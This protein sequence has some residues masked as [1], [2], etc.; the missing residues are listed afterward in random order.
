M[1]LTRILLT[2]ATGTST[3]GLAVVGSAQTIN[4]ASNISAPAIN[5]GQSPGNP[6]ATG[7]EKANNPSNNDAYESM[8]MRQ[9]RFA[10][11]QGTPTAPGTS[12]SAVSVTP[13]VTSS[14]P[15]VAK[16]LDVNGTVSVIQSTDYRYRR[17]VSVYVFSHVAGGDVAL[18]TIVNQGSDRL[19]GETRA[20]A[21]RHAQ[22]S[23]SELIDTFGDA[24][25]ASPG[26]WAQARSEMAQGYERYAAAVI[27][28]ENIATG[29]VV[30]AV[31]TSP[32]G[33]LV[34]SAR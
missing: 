22:R 24:I 23:R 4:T 16:F 19:T 33:V 5:P 12:Q 18:D 8:G 30:S 13:N 10:A 28:V 1:K 25:A 17:D 15:S 7:I 2:L 26:D 29:R 32:N 6:G 34:A 3:V 20:Q 11:S 27:H 9:D 21:L 31:V 14:T